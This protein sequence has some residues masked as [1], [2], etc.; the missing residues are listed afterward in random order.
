MAEEVVL[1]KGHRP[2]SH[3]LRCRRL[4]RISHYSAIGGIGNSCRTETLGDD[5]HGGS[6]G[7]K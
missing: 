1:M 6:S 2:R 4:L 7:R 5:R 3:P